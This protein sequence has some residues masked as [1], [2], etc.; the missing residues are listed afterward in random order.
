LPE[1]VP[2][3]DAPSIAVTQEILPQSQW[4]QLRC[5]PG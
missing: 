4:A 3:T 5:A 2:R 1:G